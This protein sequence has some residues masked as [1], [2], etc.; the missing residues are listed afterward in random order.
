MTFQHTQRELL[1]HLRNPEQNPAPTGLEDR[2]LKV[3]RDLIYNN[4]EGFIRGGFPILF[5]VLNNHQWQQLVRGFIDQHASSSPY[6]LD[7]SK[8]FVS[9]LQRHHA[10][11]S[12]YPGFLLE[13]A[14]Y[15]WVELALD[16]S[17]EEWPQCPQGDLLA[18]RP[19]VSPLVWC[20]SYQYPV[21]HIGPAFQPVEPPDQA[22]FLVV[23][24]NAEDCVKFME[25]NAVTHRLIQLLQDDSIRCGEQ[26]LRQIAQELSAPDPQTIVTMGAE[27][28]NKLLNFGI[29]CGVKT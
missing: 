21:H 26:V 1:A 11:S 2:R 17:D 10:D 19:L 4:I 5:G 22:T 27:L 15:E 14:H 9:Y 20:L 23:Y 7:I 12:Q 29:I 3:Y 6:F 18:A 13:L 28:L 16:V 24:R 25:S 8:E